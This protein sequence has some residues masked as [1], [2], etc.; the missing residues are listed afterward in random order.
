MNLVRQDEVLEAMFPGEQMPY[1]TRLKREKILTLLSGVPL[2][3]A[4]QILS[5]A[6]M[7]LSDRASDIMDRQ[8]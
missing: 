1:G 8:Q 2:H 7:D 3:R 5:L 4:I 6:L